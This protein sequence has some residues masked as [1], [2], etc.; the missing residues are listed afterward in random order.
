MALQHDSVR[1]A[2]TSPVTPT[3]DWLT[4]L[5]IVLLFA[6]VLDVLVRRTQAQARAATE[7]KRRHAREL[8]RLRRELAVE[9]ERTQITADMHEVVAQSLES[10]EAQEVHQLLTRLRDRDDGPD[11]V[12]FER[13]TELVER[14]RSLGMDL[15][16]R[17]VGVPH[18]S[19]LVAVT[20]YRLFGEAVDNAFRHGDLHRPVV[21]EEDWTDGYTLR[22]SN[23]IDPGR[24]TS[25]LE[26]GLIGMRER[27][28]IAGG[29]LHAGRKDDR[30]VVEA[31]IP[32]NVGGPR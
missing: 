6:L 23:A 20:A 21:A 16:F 17:Q 18:G 31:H 14:M 32:Q 1:I 27:T 24:R 13:R 9:R 8:R 4:A 22:V 30:W 3:R 11:R 19:G 5:A 7:R 26:H 29:T 10:A 25:P 28:A 15:H 12:E 2:H